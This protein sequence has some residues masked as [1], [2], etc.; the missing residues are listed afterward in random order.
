MHSYEKSMTVL[1]EKDGYLL[2]FSPITL[3][4]NKVKNVILVLDEK[5]YQELNSANRM[6]NSNDFSND[7]VIAFI[8]EN[9]PKEENIES[10][11]KFFE[12]HVLRDKRSNKP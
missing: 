7:D 3:Q 11:K 1:G 2:V 12:K 6:L 10:A 5:R 4:S 9:P 8:K